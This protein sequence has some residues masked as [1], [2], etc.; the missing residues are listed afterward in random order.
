M[1]SRLRLGLPVHIM[2]KV[3]Y[4]KPEININQVLK[5]EDVN[6]LYSMYLWANFNNTRSYS[7]ITCA[8]INDGCVV[9]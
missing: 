1:V 4:E 5:R 2:D 8:S 3:K 9:I 7:L 6:T